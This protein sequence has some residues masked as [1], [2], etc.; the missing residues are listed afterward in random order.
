MWMFSQLR[1]QFQLA[2]DDDEHCIGKKF[3]LS[4]K[5][6]LAWNVSFFIPLQW[7]FDPSFDTKFL[8]KCLKGDR[9]QNETGPLIF[10]SIK[11]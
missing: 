11:V 6:L 10:S 2:F 7:K 4:D 9:G 8:V 1:Q 5:G 3:A